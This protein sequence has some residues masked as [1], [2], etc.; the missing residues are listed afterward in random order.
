MK[1]TQDQL[2]TFIEKA[3]ELTSLALKAAQEKR[4]EDVISLLENRER[5]I[6][7]TQSLSEKLALH[8]SNSKDV[9]LVVQFN[10]QVNQIIDKV[11]KMDDII[12]E[13]LEHEKNKTQFEIAKTYKNKEDFKGYNLNR[14]K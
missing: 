3:Y 9:D 13:C 12:T 4:F 11:Y 10:N 5:A 6:N 1:D 14:I 7:I 8:Q 2:I